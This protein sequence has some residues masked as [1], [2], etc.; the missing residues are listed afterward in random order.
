[1][2]DCSISKTLTSTSTS[3]SASLDGS[4]SRRAFS[5]ITPIYIYVILIADSPICVSPLIW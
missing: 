3:A 2:I 1:M 4:G 5:L